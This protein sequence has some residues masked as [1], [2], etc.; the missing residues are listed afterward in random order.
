MVALEVMEIDE[1]SIIPFFTMVSETYE[2][3]EDKDDFEEFRQKLNE[4][5]EFGIERELFLRHVDETDRMELVKYLVELGP[6]QVRM[7][8]DEIQAAQAMPAED[9]DGEVPNRA[10]FVADLQTYSGYWDRTEEGWQAFADAFQEYAEGTHGRVAVAFFER[11]AAGEDKV[12]LFAEFEVIFDEVAEDAEAGEM[13]NRAE[14]VADLQT[15]SGYWDRTEEGWQAFVD[16]FQAYAEGTHGRVAVAF[17][18]RAAAGEDKVALFAEFE[19]IF[20]DVAEVANGADGAGGGEEDRM[21]DAGEQFAYLWADFDGTRESWDQSRDWTYGAANDVDP[22]LYAALYERF[23][24]LE[25]QPMPERIAQ[26]NEWNFAI[27]AT[28]EEDENAAYAALGDMFDEEAAAELRGKVELA[29]TSSEAIAEADVP[30][31]Q[32]AFEQVL[33]QVPGATGLTEDQIAELMAR[34]EQELGAVGTPQ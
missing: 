24:Q 10:E 20:D 25:E 34:A 3:I 16:A 17:F 6:D 9:D 33:T 15:Y 19:V 13:P 31:I 4:R 28:G 1:A 29:A 30:L 5:S 2:S 14:F 26:L 27:T 12:A 23:Q 32:D 8:W 7:E 22:D 18:E 11:A 21:K